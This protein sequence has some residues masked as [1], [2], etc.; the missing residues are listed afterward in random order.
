MALQEKS[1]LRAENVQKSCVPVQKK[2]LQ[3]RRYEPKG[4][5]SVLQENCRRK[6]L[7]HSGLHSEIL[8]VYGSC[9]TKAKS[10]ENLS[11]LPKQNVLLELTERVFVK[12]PLESKITLV[13]SGGSM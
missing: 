7:K 6:K 1:F 2:R 5:K 4:G 11:H 10:L 3:K 9:P 12:R 13:V 8:G